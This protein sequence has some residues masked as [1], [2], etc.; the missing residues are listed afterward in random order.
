M[1]KM[2]YEK[3]YANYNFNLKLDDEFFEKVEK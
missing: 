3:S 2:I 1:K